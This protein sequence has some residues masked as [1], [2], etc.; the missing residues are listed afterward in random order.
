[1]EVIY[2]ANTPT[3]QQNNS[4]LDSVT[5]CEIFYDVLVLQDT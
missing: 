3:L 1:M 4:L 2:F 5:N